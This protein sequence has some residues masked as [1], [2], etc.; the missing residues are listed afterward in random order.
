MSTPT[1]MSTKI[2]LLE[3]PTY[4][5][6]QV[7]RLLLLH[8]GTARRWIDGYTR[9]G[10]AYPPVIRLTPTGDDLVTWGEFVETRFLAEYRRKDIPM[11][12]LRPTIEALRERFQTKYPLAHAQP[13]L[14]VWGRELVYEAQE[15]V[16][17][18]RQLYLVVL[19]NK[20]LVLADPA[21][22][23]IDSIDFGAG[24]VAERVRPMAEV[25]EVVVDPLRQFGAPVVRNVPTEVI[26]EQ[27][28][29]GDSPT[30][31]AQ[32]YELAEQEVNAAVRYELMRLQAAVGTAA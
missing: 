7:D 4:G 31:I 9:A 6:T 30:S 21:A 8:S 26:A 13:F 1:N 25:Q 24:E 22:H 2:D 32:L 10:R 3:R 15:E 23:F 20:Q 17:L 5:M 28:R 18:E 11:H 16:G 12:H 14:Q 29:A 19:R 27:V